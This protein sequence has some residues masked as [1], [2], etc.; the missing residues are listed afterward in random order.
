MSGDDGAPP[1]AREKS[2]TGLKL[3]RRARFLKEFVLHPQSTGAVTSSSRFLARR[4]VEDAGIRPGDTVADYGPGNGAI[5]RHLLHYLERHHRHDPP[6]FFAV[7]LN[8]EFAEEL[9]RQFPGLSV[10][11]GCASNIAQCLRDEGRDG[12]DAVVSGLPWAAF[13][14]G[15]QDKLLAAMLRALRPG[16][17]FVTFAY[18]QG[19]MLPAGR[20]FRKKIASLFSD[21][22][23][24]PVVWRN[25]PPA[26]VYR[27]RVAD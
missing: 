21:V 18:L 11:A 13:P 20:R 9:R 23:V 8:A 2:L 7:E 12:L 16:A 3:R 26:I 24:S 14:D 5:T 1:P 27:C 17:R 10:R 4:L 22:T 25:I 15:L 19:T 6:H